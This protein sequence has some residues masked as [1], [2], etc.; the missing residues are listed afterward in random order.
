[1]SRV[2]TGSKI[3]TQ[4]PT[5]Y[6]SWTLWNTNTYKIYWDKGPFDPAPGLP[7]TWPNLA[8]IADPVTYFQLLLS[9]CRLPLSAVPKEWDG[10]DQTNQPV[11]FRPF[12]HC[13]TECHSCVWK[14][15]QGRI[16]AWADRAAHWPIV[17]PEAAGH[18]RKKQSAR[19]R[20]RAVI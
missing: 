8:K 3:L 11:I 17:G 4:D 9:F 1:M 13:V 18:G 15:I 12:K 20:G 10:P 14:S 19:T 5:S 16:Q 6:I 7:V 2:G